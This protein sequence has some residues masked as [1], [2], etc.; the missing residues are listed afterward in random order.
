MS[1]TDEIKDTLRKAPRDVGV[2]LM[3]DGGGR[4]LY[5][6]KAKNLRS[7]VRSYFGGNDSRPSIPF[8]VSKVRH[9]DFIVTNTE[10]EALILENNLIKEYRPR[11]NVYFR[12]DKDYISLRVDFERPFPRLEV[13]RRPEKDG[14][15]YLGPYAS[16]TAVKETLHFLQPIFPL[17]T[18]GEAEFRRRKRPCLEYEIKRCLAPC[19]G[20][21]S[22]EAYR[23]ILEDAVTFLRGGERRLLSDLRRRMVREARERRFEEAARTR[24]MIVAIE[25]TLEKQRVVSESRTNIDVFGLCREEG[26]TWTCVIYVRDGRLV[27]RK[28]F[29]TVRSDMGPAAIISSL[30]KQYYDRGVSVPPE[31]LIPV[32]IEDKAV[33]EEWLSEKRGGKVTVKRPLR[34]EKKAL[35]DMAL[36][37]ARQLFEAGKSPHESGEAT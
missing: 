15:V 11:Y 34:G 2:Y 29:P 16:S 6:G 32:D 36:N 28:A 7:R 17:R 19:V 4:V 9:I 13:V 26:S 12:D 22:P 8:L 18:C 30:L 37:N 14:A 23:R 25:R 5:V 20:R 21:V 35:L 3:K 27:G 1:M 10:K 33:T 31:V 24:N